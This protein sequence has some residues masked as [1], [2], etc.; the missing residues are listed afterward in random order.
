[1][2]ISHTATIVATAQCMTDSDAI[3]F[4]D[5]HVSVSDLMEWIEEM[6]PKEMPTFC[7]HGGIKEVIENVE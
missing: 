3:D 6:S 7:V 4:I 1:M 2:S 5:E